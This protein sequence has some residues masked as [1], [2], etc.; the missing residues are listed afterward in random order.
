MA[1]LIA[2]WHSCRAYGDQKV[3]LELMRP[4]EMCT[5]KSVIFCSKKEDL[6]YCSLN[7]NALEGMAY[8]SF[9]GAQPWGKVLDWAND[10]HTVVNARF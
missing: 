3:M 2:I 6:K 10:N 4:N 7:N 1:V 9:V 8:V 5:I